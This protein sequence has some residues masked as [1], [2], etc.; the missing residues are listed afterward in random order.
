MKESKQDIWSFAQPRKALIQMV[1][2]FC[3]GMV[4]GIFHA[5]L[6]ITMT[7]LF[8]IEFWRIG[9][10]MF[11]MNFRMRLKKRF[12]NFGLMGARL[13]PDQNE[14]SLDMSPEMLQSDDHLFSIDRTIKMSF[15]DL[16]R[17]RQYNHRGCLSAKLGDPLQSR[18]LTFWCPGKTNRFRIRKPKL[19]FKHD[20]CVEPPRFF[21]SSANPCSTMLGSIL[22]LVQSLSLQ[23][24]A[25]SSLTHSTID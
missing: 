5:S 21:L 18:R 7:I 2:N 15:V 3:L 20:L 9:W 13:I 12:H 19:I 6:D 16:A 22:R 10:Q 17:N 11:A 23:A 8:W 1:A 24:F 14:R 4:Y 25:H